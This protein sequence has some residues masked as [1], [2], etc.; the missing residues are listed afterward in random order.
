MVAVDCWCL[1]RYIYYL[2]MKNSY[3]LMTMMIVQMTIKDYS[4]G[5]TK[6]HSTASNF[7]MMGNYSCSLSVADSIRM[8]DDLATLNSNY[9]DYNLPSMNCPHS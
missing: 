7:A 2:D 4:R 8:L 5:W 1:V 3:S 6:T 9:F